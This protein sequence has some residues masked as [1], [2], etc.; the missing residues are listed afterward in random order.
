MRFFCIDIVNYDK[1]G[2]SLACMANETVY[3][4]WNTTAGGDSTI[5][6]SG[7]NIGNYYPSQIPQYACDNNITDE[8]TN[9]GACNSSTMLMTCGVNTGFYRTPQRGPSLIIGLQ[10]CTGSNLLTRDPITITFEG[11]NQ[12][13]SLLNLGTSWALLYSGPSGLATDPGRTAWGSPQFFTNNSVWYS[14]YR[15][16]VTS[17]RGVQSST[18]YSEVQLIGY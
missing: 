16:L 15:F 18:W 2:S 12:P 10:I 11:S 4:V 1:I 6:T 8:Y 13:T 17:K 3:G 5:S 7:S 14:S 9:F